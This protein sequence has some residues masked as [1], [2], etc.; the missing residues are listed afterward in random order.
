[1]LSQANT[2]SADVSLAELLVDLALGK[3]ILNFNQSS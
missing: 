2:L 1:M 3:N